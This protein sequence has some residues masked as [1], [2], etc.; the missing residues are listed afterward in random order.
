[1]RSQPRFAVAVAVA[2][3]AAAL[4]FATGGVQA[5]SPGAGSSVTGGQSAPAAQP[6]TGTRNTPAQGAKLARGDRRFIE[7]AANSG[8]FEVQVAQLA[9]AK[10]TDP[11]VRSFASMLVDHHTAANNELV[12]IAN[13]R[14]V[15]LP[16]APKRALRRDVEKLGKKN[17]D[18]FDRDFVRNV[19][20]KAHEK[21][22][23]TFQ[24]ASKDV[25]DAQLKAFVDKTLPVLREHL[26][27]AEKL[28]QSGKNAAAMGANRK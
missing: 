5:Q 6:G 21:D 14:G 15:E 11:N 12:Q 20:I 7:D 17:G 27:A 19:G 13:A 25:K 23:K 16:A 1:M 4:L 24:K 3:A 10:A 18:E 26:A 28:P 9:A 2:A 22:I 8:M